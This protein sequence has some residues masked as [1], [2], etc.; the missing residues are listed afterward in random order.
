MTRAATLDAPRGLRWWEKAACIDTPH[1]HTADLRVG[2]IG[3]DSPHA[4]ARHIC[5][6]HCPVIDD[7]RDDIADRTPRGVVQAG[8]VY[9]DTGTARPRAARQQP[10]DPG[11]GSWC[12]GMPLVREVG[13]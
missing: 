2:V 5:L 4:Q 7:C 1:L 3:G 9:P 8:L 13:R 11:C 6:T 12:A 10:P